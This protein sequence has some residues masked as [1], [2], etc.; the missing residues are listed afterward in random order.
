MVVHK[1]G[2]AGRK[3]SLMVTRKFRGHKVECSVTAENSA[4]SA[5]ATSPP[6]AVA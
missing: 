6:F 5:T 4:G 1:A 2:V 3:P